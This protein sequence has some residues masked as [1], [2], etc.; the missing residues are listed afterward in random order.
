M[1]ISGKKVLIFGGWGLVGSAVCRELM[2][3]H[4][5]KIFVSSLRKH[6]AEDAVRQLRNEFPNVPPETFEAKWGNIFARNDWK[7]MD[8]SEVLSNPNWRREV[9]DDIYCELNQEILDKSALYT[10]IKECQPDIVI[11]CV[12]TA[13]AIAYQDIYKGVS[14]VRNAIE[15]HSLSEEIVEKLMSS[16]YIPQ[17]IRHIQILYKGLCDFNVKMYLKVGTSGT[18]GMG[19]NIPYTHSEERPSRVLLSKS[20]V[21]GAQTLLLYLMARTPNG[22]LIKEIKPT[23]AIAWK[24]IAFDN[25]I[26]KGKPVQIVDMPFEKAKPTVGTFKFNDTDGVVE[27][28]DTFKSVFIDTGENGIF[29][30]GEFEA[31]SALGQMEIVTPEEIALYA[32]HEILGGNTGKDVI[33]GLDAFTLGPTYR[34]GFL[35]S[36]A[37][38]K[39]KELELENNVESIAFELLG[40]PRLSKLLFEANILKHC[41]GSMKNLVN[42]TA[43]EISQKSLEI[44]KK[45]VKLRSQMLSIGLVI[46]LPDG[47]SYLRGKEVKIPAQGSQAELELTQE[48]INQWCKEGWVDLRPE[49]F[50]LWKTR[51]KAI[52]EQIEKQ[53]PNDTSSRYNYTRQYW[54]NFE[55]FN[56]GKIVAWIFENE[57]HGWRFKR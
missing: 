19:L 46:L 12:N 54:D 55:G 21:A 36:Y 37:V 1:E 50:D 44:I 23:A 38:E 53:I 57:D 17:L 28:N 34:G 5:A 22:P 35:Q 30:R 6:E 20:A 27:T 24:R 31:I 4:P 43:K 56:E 8:W 33:Q 11:D 52:M 2:K 51:I 9:L 47:K 48:N 42:F 7:D 39:L 29:S 25:V 45:N 40:P 10:L 16:I 32:V 15:S 18:G 14:S 26:R 41:V 13:T 3:H 49:N